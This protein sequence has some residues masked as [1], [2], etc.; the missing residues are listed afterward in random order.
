[1]PGM[2]TLINAGGIILGG[3]LGLLFGRLLAPRLQQTLMKSCG[4]CVLFLGISGAME[5][6]LSMAADG[7]LTSGGTMVIVAS[8][9]LGALAGELINIDGA[10]ER[11]GEWL[12]RVTGSEGDGGFVGGF[13]NASLTVCIGAMAIVGAIQDGI[14]G[15]ISTLVTKSVLDC[16]IVMIMTAASGKGCIFSAVPVIVLQGSVTAL[17]RLIE[18]VMTTAALDN[19]SMVGSILIFCVGVN[20]VWGKLVRVANLLPAMVFAVAQAFVPFF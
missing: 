14:L 7:A 18:P 6:M 2:G 4:V 17:S 13:V 12:K 10:M 11:F 15:D 8:L 5:K 9:A 16:I 19:L 3:L 1:M 20:L